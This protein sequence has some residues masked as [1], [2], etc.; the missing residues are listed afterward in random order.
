[1]SENQEA[2]IDQS[3][4]NQTPQL[5]QE[6]KAIVPEKKPELTSEEKVAFDQ[7]SADL[8]KL[9]GSRGNTNIADGPLGID[10]KH[11]F[12][13]TTFKNL[14]PAQIQEISMAGPFQKHL[15][16]IYDFLNQYKGIFRKTIYFRTNETVIRKRSRF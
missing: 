8:E 3:N 9:I 16:D 10:I 1:M 11:K 6:I 14:S 12:L 7:V 4:V 2:Q 15:L 13:V 5:A